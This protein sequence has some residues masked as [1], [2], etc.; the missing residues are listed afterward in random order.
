MAVVFII[1]AGVGGNL[2]AAGVVL[3]VVSQPLVTLCASCA[4]HDLFAAVFLGLALLSTFVFMTAPSPQSFAWLWTQLLALSQA[5]YESCLLF[6]VIPGILFFLGYLREEYFKR[7]QYLYFL[8]PI[9]F[10]PV[11]LQHL[12][13]QGALETP[14]GVPAFSFHHLGVNL[15]DMARSQ[16]N[17]S[18]YQAYNNLLFWLAVPA[19]LCLFRQFSRRPPAPSREQQRHFAWIA[20]VS[21]AA[22]C[23]VS[24]CFHGGLFSHAAMARHYVGLAIAVSLLPF[25]LRLAYPESV[26]PGRFLLFSAA[27]FILYHPIAVENRLIN[28]LN[29]IR[30][31]EAEIAFLEAVPEHRRLVI[32]ERPGQFTALNYG[33]VDFNYAAANA[34]TLLSDLAR[35]LYL[36]IL[37]FQKISYKTE[38]PIPE[39]TLSLKLPLQTLQEIQTT[40]DEYLRISRVRPEIKP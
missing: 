31:T 21:I 5:R 8:T 32:A 39:N 27:M 26:T 29:L 3:L 6:I 20:I 40:A 7:Y 18:Y 16:F 10:L 9:L 15:M 35:H 34:Q 30:E 25:G 37:V 22:Y 33:A 36:E 1:C 4:G 12:L 24:L 13:S 38:R 11:I 28:S 19:A 2:G 23:A 17:F 14:P